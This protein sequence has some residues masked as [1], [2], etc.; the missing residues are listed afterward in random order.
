MG[1]DSPEL[2][3]PLQKPEEQTE[4]GNYFV[5]N[6]PPFSFWRPDYVPKVTELI[7]SP[8]PESTDLGVYF[9]IPFCRKRCHFCYFRVYTDKN[10]E[11]IGRYVEAL[12]TEVERV[13]TKPAL[14]GRKLRFMYFGGGTPSYIAVKQLVPLVERVRAA[15]D[16]SELE[17]FAFECEPGTL[18]KSKLEALSELGVTRLS[19]GVENFNDRILEENGRAHL[20]EEIY[21]VT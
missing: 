11:Q 19:L 21:R 7:E 8:A 17:E 15:I 4:A 16:T 3:T 13:A 1:S 9:H 18:T 2:T 10:A 14:A 5:A 6:Y 20:S 12:G